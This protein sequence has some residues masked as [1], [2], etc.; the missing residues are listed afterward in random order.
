[1]EPSEQSAGLRHIEGKTV[2][3]T[4]R[5]L[6]CL[7]SLPAM[8]CVARVE[9]VVAPQRIPDSYAHA[10]TLVEIAP[11]RRLNL[12]CEGTGTPTMLLEAGAHADTTTW[13]RLQPLL[14]T[15]YRVCSYDRAGYGFSDIGPMPRDLNAD[16]SDL[17][18]L[19]HQAGLRT[20]LVLVGH[21]LG[22]NIVR[23]YAAAHASDVSGLVLIDPPAQNVAAYAPVWAKE[24]DALAA[25]RFTFLDECKAA[26]EK[27][28]LAS[29][30][31]A[32]QHC[33]AAGN[34]LAGDPVNAAIAAYKRTPAFWQTLSSELHSNATIFSQPVSSGESLGALPMIVLSAS[35]TY[36]DVPAAV[37]P[38]LELAK[39]KTQAAIA[40]TSTRSQR[41]T[42]DHASHDI[43]LD[44]PQAVAK[45]VDDVVRKASAGKK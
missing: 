4:Y 32:L 6:A 40:A 16:V 5:L 12:R 44:Q 18:A 13:F 10:G 37:R 21:S 33:V 15:H 24:D 36:A 2:K 42:V 1:M 7:L 9:P 41:I 43:Q 11:G 31:P 22:T 17:H 19:I 8:A 20:P 26:A 25:Q 14:A 29:P 34:P 35:G 45:A 38:S 3:G 30:P 27:H 28:Q 39:D 23:R